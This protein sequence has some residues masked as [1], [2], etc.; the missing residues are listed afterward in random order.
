MTN[1]NHADISATISVIGAVVTI[2][3]I[4][5]FVSLFA[6]LVAIVSG[7]FAIRYYYWKTKHMNNEKH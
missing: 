2:S 6:G 7:I 5:P 4:Q 1:H 3:S